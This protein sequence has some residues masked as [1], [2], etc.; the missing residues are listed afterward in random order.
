MA[1]VQ[2]TFKRAMDGGPIE[3]AGFSS[4]QTFT[5]SA[6]SQ[7]T[8]GS[9][10]NNDIMVIETDGNIRFTTGENPT[11]VADD[12]CELVQAGRYQFS[13]PRGHKCA[14]IDA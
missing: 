13:I 6:S 12:T 5:S 10:H 1:T 4:N 9:A 14:I 8:T 2:V 7:Q 11:A 3:S